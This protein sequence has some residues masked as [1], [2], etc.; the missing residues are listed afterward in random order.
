MPTD[1]YSGGPFLYERTEGGCRVHAANDSA[2]DDLEEDRL[3][4]TF[5][6]DQLPAMAR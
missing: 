2:P 1:P 6:D 3:G 5:R 4:W